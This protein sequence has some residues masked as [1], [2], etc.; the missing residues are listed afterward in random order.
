MHS[1]NITA[2]LKDAF[3]QYL[4]DDSYIIWGKIHNDSK[5]RFKNGDFV[6]TSTVI[7][8]LGND[9]YKTLNSVYKVESLEDDRA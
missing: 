3:K 2:E 4:P 8:Y 6:H 5:G 1:V 7:S 9:L